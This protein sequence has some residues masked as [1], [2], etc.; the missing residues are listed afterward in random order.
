[1]I[2]LSD[3][4]DTK[5]SSLGEVLKMNVTFK[6]EKDHKSKRA[7]KTACSLPNWFLHSLCDGVCLLQHQKANPFHVV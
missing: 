6:V 1:M 2:K 7:Q 4:L 5:N 3:I